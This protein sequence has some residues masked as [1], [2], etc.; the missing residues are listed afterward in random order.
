[1]KY[2]ENPSAV[3]SQ[4]QIIDSLIDLMQLKKLSEIS[5]TEISENAGV[6]RRTF[7]RH[8]KSKEEI[9][10]AYFYILVN[11]L[12]NKLNDAEDKID[13]LYAIK[14]ILN[15]CYENQDFFKALANS[16]M[17]NYMLEKWTEILPELHTQFL[18]KLKNFP[19]FICGDELEYLLAF[20]TGGIYNIVMKWI[21]DGMTKTP[22]E[23][24]RIIEKIST[25]T[26]I[27]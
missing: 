15:L 13:T 14:N 27:A 11:E 16:G 23:I 26:L 10:D 3:Y 1:M 20:N 4:K 7:Y 12:K 8:F 17:L 22:D 24:Y 9:L 19:D 18:D 6:V 25:G 2:T 5:I 21:R